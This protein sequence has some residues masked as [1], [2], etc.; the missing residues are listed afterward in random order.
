MGTPLLT[1]IR[2]PAMCI[3]TVEDSHMR[4]DIVPGAIFP[5]YEFSDHRASW[6]HHCTKMFAQTLLGRRSQWGKS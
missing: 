5:D 3:Q 4:A 2:N 1:F 6:T